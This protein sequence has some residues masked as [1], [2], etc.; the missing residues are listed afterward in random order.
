MSITTLSN[1]PIGKT[2]K[3]FQVTEAETN[4]L[5][6]GA[7]FGNPID[8]AFGPNGVY[9]KNVPGNDDAIRKLQAMR[10]EAVYLRCANEHDF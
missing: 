1:L 5:V 4:A 2:P 10:Q 3:H 9:L 6:M 8:F 7:G